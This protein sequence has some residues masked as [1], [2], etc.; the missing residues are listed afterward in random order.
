MDILKNQWRS[1]G[2]M[3]IDDISV[4]LSCGRRKSNGLAF[5]R[6]K[7]MFWT[8]SHKNGHCDG[9]LTT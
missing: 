9:V 7:Q 4:M 5:R 6:K 1:T 2:G 3:F 8:K